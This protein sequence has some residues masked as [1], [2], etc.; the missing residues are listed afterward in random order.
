MESQIDSFEAEMEG[1]TVK[2]GKTRPP[3]LVHKDAPLTISFFVLL[4]S[5]LLTD[6]VHFRHIWK[7]L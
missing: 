4:Y 1:L 5:L 6:D 2:K 3:R 7:L